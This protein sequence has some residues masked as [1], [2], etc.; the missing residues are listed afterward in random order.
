MM[1]SGR[2][3]LKAPPWFGDSVKFTP[4]PIR[5]SIDEV[6]NQVRIDFLS[7]DIPFNQSIHIDISPGFVSTSNIQDHRSLHTR[8]KG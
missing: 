4:S 8:C 3:V 7:V 1:V 5:G 2:S 6:R